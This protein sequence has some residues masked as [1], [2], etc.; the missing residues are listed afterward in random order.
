MSCICSLLVCAT[1]WSKPPFLASSTGLPPSTPAPH[2]TA[3]QQNLLKIKPLSSEKKRI[4]LWLS[5]AFG[6]KCSPIIMASKALSDQGNALL[7]PQHPSLQLW[8]SPPEL[9]SHP[10]RLSL[11][12]PRD[13][14]HFRYQ[15]QVGSPG[16]SYL[17]PTGY[18]FPQFPQVREFTRTIQNSRKCTYY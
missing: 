12:L 18:K 3:A 2:P 17:W 5:I 15:L 13:C 16:P 10:T 9:V 7:A 8:H 6:M 14:L 1:L 4:F 11:S